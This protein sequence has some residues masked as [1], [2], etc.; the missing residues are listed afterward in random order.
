MDA[1]EAAAARSWVEFGRELRW[2]RRAAG[3]T[4]SQLGQRVGYHH[5]VISRVESGRREPPA[6]LVRRLD[7]VLA[8]NGALVA[9]E[10]N[11]APRGATAS[12]G[13]PTLFAATPGVLTADGVT[14]PGVAVWPTRL[15][16][17]GVACPLH[18]DAGCAVPAPGDVLTTV[19]GLVRRRRS[20]PPNRSPTSCT[21][22]PR[23]CRATRRP[24]RSTSRPT[25]WAPSRA[26]DGRRAPWW[27]GGLPDRVVT[28]RWPPLG[29][30]TGRPFVP[31]PFIDRVRLRSLTQRKHCTPRLPLRHSRSNGW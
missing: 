7:D 6:G 23:C 14:P 17:A 12:A 28:C 16:Y 21:G 3:L 15:P 1:E 2:W 8:A 31:A 18:G 4:Q 19:A 27:S 20:C 11:R 13:D 29:Q 22:W 25:S 26:C 9:L 24:P 30:V 5:S 10:A